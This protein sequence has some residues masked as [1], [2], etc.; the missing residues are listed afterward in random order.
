[1]ID[2]GKIAVLKKERKR[3]GEKMAQ[4]RERERKINEQDRVSDMNGMR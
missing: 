2:G 4:M 3:S 1:M